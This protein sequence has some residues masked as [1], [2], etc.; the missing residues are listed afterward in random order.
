MES[1]RSSL[2]VLLLITMVGRTSAQLSADQV[3]KLR[4]ILRE[5]F[6]ISG[7]PTTTPKPGT[8][9]TTVI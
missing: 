4:D 9:I 3:T 5:R 2:L 1:F 8:S 7:I 6:G